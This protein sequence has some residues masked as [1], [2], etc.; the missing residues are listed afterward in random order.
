MSI[1]LKI[2]NPVTYKLRYNRF[3]TAGGISG[4]V[5]TSNKVFLQP[6]EGVF[7]EFSLMDSGQDLIRNPETL[8]GKIDS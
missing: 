4:Y 6:F 8:C 1:L 5:V 2:I 7:T 3:E